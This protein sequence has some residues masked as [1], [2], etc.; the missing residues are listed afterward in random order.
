MRGDLQWQEWNDAT[1]DR[2]KQEDKIIF[3]R[4]DGGVTIGA[5]PFAHCGT[6]QHRLLC[7]SLV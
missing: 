7:M 2:A 6:G 5:D 4:L 1:I 3:L